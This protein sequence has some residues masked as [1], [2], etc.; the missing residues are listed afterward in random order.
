MREQPEGSPITGLRAPRAPGGTRPCGW[1]C[2]G[3]YGSAG[4]SFTVSPYSVT[5]DNL[6]T[7]NGPFIKVTQLSGETSGRFRVA[8]V[9]ARVFPTQKAFADGIIKE[10]I[11]PASDFP[12][13]PYLTDALKYHGDVTVEF[14]TPANTEGLGTEFGLQPNDQPISGV[15]ALKWDGEDI[16]LV[17]LAVR[18]MPD[19]RDLTA[20]IIQQFER[21]QELP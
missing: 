3:T 1:H 2:F 9:I 20:Q 5:S 16:Y 10:G 11:E 18:L 14:Q 12:F 6:D 19:T 17:G 7:L 4:T 13:G 15:A 8:R 21:D